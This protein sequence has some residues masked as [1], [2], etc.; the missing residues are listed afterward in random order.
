MGNMLV[1]NRPSNAQINLEDKHKTVPEGKKE[2][3]RFSSRK[4]DE[5]KIA[6]QQCEEDANSKKA[7]THANRIQV[8]LSEML[9]NSPLD[10]GSFPSPGLDLQEAC[11]Q[12]QLA[13]SNAP[14]PAAMMPPW[15]APLR[16]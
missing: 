6:D 1:L 14:P 7:K 15:G 9:R 4:R 2:L 10:G 5:S 11:A 16:K 3:A 12:L 8:V 13:A